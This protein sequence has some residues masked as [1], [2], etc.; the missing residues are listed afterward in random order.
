MSIKNYRSRKN[1]LIDRGL[2]LGL[3]V[4][5][6][7]RDRRTITFWAGV[8]PALVWG[9]GLGSSALP[10][11]SRTETRRTHT[12][13]AGVCPAKVWG[14]V[15]WVRGLEAH[16]EPLTT[17]FIRKRWQESK[18]FDVGVLCVCCVVVCVLCC[19]V[20]VVLLCCCVVLCCV[21][22]Y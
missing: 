4:P 20:C 6:A 12:F 18:R 17:H 7:D 15:V 19:C 2:L 3:G 8:C 13:L 16:G 22:L 11:L 10:L 9:G 5:P 1:S 14:G 21:V